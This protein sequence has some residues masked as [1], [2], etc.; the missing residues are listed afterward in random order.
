MPRQLPKQLSL[1][2]R[3]ALVG[4]IHLLP[5]PGSPGQRGMQESLERARQ[6]AQVLLDTGFDAL[7][8]ENMHDFPPLRERDMGPEVP[9]Y[10]AVLAREIRM[11]APPEVPVGIQVLF[12]AHRVAVAVARAAGLDFLRAE[13]WSYGH[14][15]DKGWVEASAAV[16][17]R[18]ARALGMEKL[19]IWADLKKKHA[20]HAA[21]A[22]LSIEDIASTLELHGADAAIITGPSTGQ[23]P[24]PEDFHRVRA[25][26]SL[27]LVLGSGLTVQ[28]APLFTGLADVLIVG[29]SLKKDAKWWNPIDLDR[30]KELVKVVR[31]D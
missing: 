21:T 19:A 24:D 18:Y 1:A 3:P 5:S 10:L 8:L 6:D 13:A 9:S 11:L 27:P 7:L 25:S 30:A 22:D 28:N 4:M 26:T 17:L 15:S 16:T 20:S 12:A 23:A 2:H 29:S 14:L 31:G